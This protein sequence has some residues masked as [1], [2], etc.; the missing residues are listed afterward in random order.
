[1]LHKEPSLA[2]GLAPRSAQTGHKTEL[3]TNAGKRSL[4]FTVDFVYASILPS[5]NQRLTRHEA[6]WSVSRA[7]PKFVLKEIR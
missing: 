3:P 5:P 7:F 6:A 4:I 2:V 1:M